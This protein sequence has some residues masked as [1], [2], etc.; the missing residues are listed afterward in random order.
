MSTLIQLHVNDDELIRRERL[1]E[2]RLQFFLASHAET[3]GAVEFGELD[4]IWNK[5]LGADD[6]AGVVL[7]LIARQATARS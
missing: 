3:F 4:E 1:L 6:A 5:K 2:N 7:H